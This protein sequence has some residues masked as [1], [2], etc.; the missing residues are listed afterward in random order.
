MNK[1]LL[2]ST[3]IVSIIL[4]LSSCYPGGGEYVSDFDV[5]ITNYDDQYNFAGIKTY[6]I[7]DSVRYIVKE[8][9]EPDHKWDAT[10][11]MELSDQFDALGWERLDTTDIN[12]GV[13]PDADILVTIA[14]VTITSI[15][16]YPWYPGW[17]WG[18]G[19]YPDYGWG[20]PWYGGAVVTS[21]ETGTVYWNMFDPNDVDYEN[22]KIYLNWEGAL[23]GLIGSNPVNTESRI[24]QGIEQAFKQ[25]TYL[26]GN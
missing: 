22:E 9:E 16:S 13:T 21:Y 11:I 6:F 20:Y 14:K 24:K 26:S 19:G 18:W 25:S 23:N 5:V 1:F 8:G 4:L 2:R 15:Y 7:A 10:I 3:V 12:A 17:G